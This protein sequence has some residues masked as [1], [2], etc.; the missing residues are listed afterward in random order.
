[1]TGYIDGTNYCENGGYAQTENGTSS[2]W[3]DIY[4]DPPSRP[5]DSF[6]TIGRYLVTDGKDVWIEE[7]GITGFS[8]NWITHWQELPPLPR[9]TI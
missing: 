7:Y 1:M 3:I 4:A 2:G 9:K 6:I 8:N 5:D